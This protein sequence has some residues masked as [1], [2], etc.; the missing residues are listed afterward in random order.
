MDLNHCGESDSNMRL[1][2]LVFADGAI[3]FPESLEG[4]AM[5]PEALHKE[6]RP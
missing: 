2:G 5:A 6:A 4:I 3:I 1:V